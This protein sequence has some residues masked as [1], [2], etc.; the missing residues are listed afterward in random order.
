MRARPHRQ[1]SYTEGPTAASQF[2]TALGKLVKVTK[3]ELAEREAAYQ[4]E[5]S[6][7]DRPGPKPRRKTA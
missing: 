5:R 3:E 2:E 7:K 4:K 1:A 6:T